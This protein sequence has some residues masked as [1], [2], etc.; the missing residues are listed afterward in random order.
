MKIAYISTSTIPS[1][2]ANSIHVMKMCQAFANQDHEVL[3]IC[4]DKKQIENDIY[5][6][7]NFYGV[8]PIFRLKKIWY[9]NIKGKTFIYAIISTIIS[10]FFKAD[11]VY[12]RNIFSS[13]LS[14]LLRIN[15]VF[16]AHQAISDFGKLE[17]FIFR[18]LILNQQLLALITITNSLKTYLINKYNIKQQ[19]LFVA[20]DGAD[21]IPQRTKPI[22]K[23]FNKDK[24]QIGYIG[25]LYSG[26]GVE[27]IIKL[28]EKC[29]WADFHLI[30]GNDSDVLK[31]RKETNGMENIIFHGFVSPNIIKRYQISFDVLLAPYQKKVGVSSY[32][33]ISTE[34]WM[35]PLKLFEYMAS[36]KAII[37]SDIEVLNEVLIDNLNCLLCPSDDIMSWV[38]A[39]RTLKEDTILREILGI[40]AYNIFINKYTWNSRAKRIIEHLNVRLNN[41]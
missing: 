31:W 35:S 1:R 2:T 23:I 38:E 26:R 21:I 36:K 6:I 28:S 4:P 13:Y 41:N 19:L 10:K 7:F 11:I 14:S 15:V 3:L 5:D 32:T 30:G 40:N 39:L 17:E 22:D 20:P 33:N 18:K 29:S 16:E 25:H 8:K 9:P 12:S 24:C 27:L 34:K 37:C